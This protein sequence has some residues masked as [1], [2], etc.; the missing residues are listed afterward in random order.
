MATTTTLL[1]AVNRVLLD[2]GER[3][4]TSLE[5]T[6]AARKAKAYLQEAFEDLQ[7]YHNWEWAYE[8]M[9]VNS[10]NNEI[11]TIDSVRRIRAALWNTGERYYPITYVPLSAFLRWQLTSF[12]S[13]TD[14]ATRPLRWTRDDDTTLRFDPYPTDEA[15]RDKIRIEGIKYFVG[16]ENSDDTFSCPERYMNILYKRAV[17][18]MY[19]RHVGDLQMAQYVENEYRETLQNFRSQETLTPTVG[20]N[21]FNRYV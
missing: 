12:D 13:G 3:S 19:Q 20:G 15:G 6:P 14:E 7:Q 9:P 18:M 2:V 16:P 8:L 5:A 17:Y 21:M 11:T 1:E 10:F 4:V